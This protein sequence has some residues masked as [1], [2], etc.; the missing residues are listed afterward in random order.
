MT[1]VPVDR[2]PL[3]TAALGAGVLVL[4]AAAAVIGP[5]LSPYGYAQQDLT[6]L[7]APPSA[8][9]PLGTAR[10][11]EDVLTQCLRGLQKSLVIGLLAA[12]VT[13]VLS[14]VVGTLAGYLGGRVDRVLMAAVD[15]L[16]VLPPILIVA[17]ISPALRGQSW[18]LLV[19]LIAGFQWMLT[20]RVVR[21]RARSLRSADFVAA[22]E[23]MGASVGRVVF[24]HLLPQM[25]P[26]LIIDC[27]MNV[28]TAVLA[29]AG[30]SYFGFG[31][32]APDIS[33]GTLVSVGSGSALTF[34][35]VFLAPVGFLAAT[36]IGVGLLGEG[37]RGGHDEK[38]NP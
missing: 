5:A 10:L 7:F 36:V 16:L 21:A 19:V 38:R 24:R 29:E 8:D 14:A 15:I 31:V 33:L 37:L 13:T 22:A 2:G 23:Y 35:W 17:V 27:T 26:L 3:R 32:Q 4:L 18:L 25:A 20:A 30:L 12:L 11:G 28:A 34:P 1:L 9:H 6:A